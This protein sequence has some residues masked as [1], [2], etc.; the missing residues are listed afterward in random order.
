M[1]VTPHHLVDDAGKERHLIEL[2]CK[3]CL[4]SHGEICQMLLQYSF[5]QL[6]TFNLVMPGFLPSGIPVSLPKADLACWNG[7]Y[8][9]SL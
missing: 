2:N 9:P 4:T 5:F 6:L 3:L 1:P 8:N 7:A